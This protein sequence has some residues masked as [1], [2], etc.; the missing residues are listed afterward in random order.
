MR[1][2]TDELGRLCLSLRRA[3]WLTSRLATLEPLRYGQTTSPG[4]V[5]RSQPTNSLPNARYAN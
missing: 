5:I 4:V 3:C 1:Q 2:L